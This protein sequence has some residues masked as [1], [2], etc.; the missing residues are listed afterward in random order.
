MGARR[1]TATD[2]G[3][4]GGSETSPGGV[5]YKARGAPPSGPGRWLLRSAARARISLAGITRVGI[6]RAGA[7]V[8]LAGAAAVGACAHGPGSAPGTGSG[9]P[10]GADR[11]STLQSTLAA[12]SLDPSL[13]PA[14][15][16]TLRQEDVAIRIQYLGMIARFLPLDESVI[17][18]LAPDS[19]RAL[20]DIQ[21]S[22][23]DEIERMARR[24]SIVRPRLWYVSFSGLEQGETRFSPLELTV[25]SGGRDFR[26]VDAI[27]LTP[28]F[29]EQR[30][31]P[32][33]TQAALYVFDGEVN[34]DQPLTL[35][36]QTVRSTAWTATLRRIERERSLVRS[37]VSR[38]RAPGDP[39]P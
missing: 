33:E 14:G 9:P 17:R 38:N 3:T 21:A 22:K 26:P 32:R 28:G 18:L 39:P 4:D 2:R 27:A 12:D 15:Y 24:Y 37:R 23:R 10:G 19:Y 25:T 7:A 16:G 6:A 20:R 35:T 1:L 31:G 13:V 36:F 5:R 11:P 30:L 29:G 8:A 34:V